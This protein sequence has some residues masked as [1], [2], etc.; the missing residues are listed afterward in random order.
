MKKNKNIRKA[1][2]WSDIIVILAVTFVG[3]VL[4]PFG[5]GWRELGYTIIAC[6]LCMTPLYI[7]GYK[8][9]G[10]PGVF[11]EEDFQIS[12]DDKESVVSFLKGESSSLDVHRQEHGG[13]LISVYYQKKN[14]ALYAQY[15]DYAQIMEGEDNPV[16]KISAQQYE[17]LKKLV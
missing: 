12:R 6:G 11:H 14:E 17:T 7:H 13:A 3:I 16:L 10:V 2:L 15:Y 9:E 8:I 5:P 4:L 1:F